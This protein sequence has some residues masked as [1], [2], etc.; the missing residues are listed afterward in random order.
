MSRFSRFVALAFLLSAVALPG[1]RAED[2]ATVSPEVQ[3]EV[4]EGLH[5]LLEDLYVIPETAHRIEDLLR[6]NLAAGTYDG[7]SPQQFAAALTRDMQSLS[8]DKHLR[9]SFG[10]A[11]EAPTRRVIRQAPGEPMPEAG[12]GRRVVVVRPGEEPPAGMPPAG[13]PRRP[14]SGGDGGV[15]DNV[16]GIPEAKMLPGNVGYVDIR[17]FVPREM[18]EADAVAAM[19]AVA[20]A[21]ALIFDLRSCMG[22]SPDMV[23]FI[24]SYLYPPGRKHLLTYYHA[25][26]KP[27]SAYTLEEI[28]GQRMP[29]TDVYLVT[30]AFTGSGCE[31]FSYV[32]K[33]HDRA[34]LVGE[35][36]GGAGHG[37]GVHPV[38]A[39]FNA[40]IPDFRPVHPVT[41]E[42]WE[43]VGVIP[44]VEVPAEKALLVA[45]RLALEGIRGRSD[46]GARIAEL[47]DLI[48]S[49]S[50]EIA[51]VDEPEPIDREALAEYAG[52]Y[53]IRTITLE[54]DG[55]YLQR[56][57]GP[58]MKMVSTGEH[59]EFALK[60]LPQAKIRFGRDE[61]G[62]IRELHVLAL[63]G[64]WEVT[65]RRTD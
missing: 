63:Q 8:G 26:E 11:G 10:E 6:K 34:T 51:R 14:G 12:D 3:S 23:H 36:T 32:L 21:D 7:L 5:G 31:E 22:G 53:E 48:D 52:D 39:G 43:G 56:V 33:H 17:L 29:D 40:F 30:S 1:A 27:D 42:G 57:G 13:E 47:T 38:A 44:D 35:T 24:T 60:R 46:D 61:A 16:R 49:L 28:P 65:K 2:P 19:E 15:F 37:G 64:T 55:L 4:V 9:V 58:K 45:Q 50:T 41:G 20:G 59:D 54:D 25:H 62:V 18:A